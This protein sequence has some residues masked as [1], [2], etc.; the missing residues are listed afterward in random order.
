ML[1]LS[2]T[3]SNESLYTSWHWII[4]SLY[5]ILGNGIRDGFDL[6]LKFIFIVCPT[7][8]TSMSPTNEI[9]AMLDGRHNSVIFWRW[10]KRNLLSTEEGWCSLRNVY[11]GIVLSKYSTRRASKKRKD[12]WLKNFPYVTITVEV[13]GMYTRQDP[14]L[15]PI[16]PHTNMP[17]ICALWRGITHCGSKRFPQ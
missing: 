9:P 17:C 13:A 2:A 4:H 16:A 8:C 6:K 10:K 7:S 5:V 15:Y 1:C 11:T 12:L 3:L 14:A